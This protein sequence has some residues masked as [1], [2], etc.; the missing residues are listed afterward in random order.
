MGA[1]HYLKVGETYRRSWSNGKKDLATPDLFAGQTATTPREIL[2]RPV[3]GEKLAP[4][5]KYILKSA[6]GQVAAFRGTQLVGR[7]A[8]PPAPLVNAIE[9]NGAIALGTVNRVHR[10]SGAADVS[11]S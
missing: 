5:E 1:E 7:C 8:T 11:V 4:T 2:L 10:I 3:A 6:D 9:R